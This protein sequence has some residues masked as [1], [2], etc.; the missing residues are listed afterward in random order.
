MNIQDWF[1]VRI[2]WLDLLAVQ[3]TLKCLLQHHGSK[4]SVLQ[5][6][7]FFMVQF[8]HPHMTPGKTKA[9]IFGGFISHMYCCSPAGSTHCMD[10]SRS[11]YGFSI[12]FTPGPSVC[13][14][15][16]W[17]VSTSPQG[18][19]LHQG[20]VLL[21][22]HGFQ[23][24]ICSPHFVSIFLF[25]CLLSSSNIRQED[26]SE[27]HLRPQLYKVKYYLEVIS[28]WNPDWCRGKWCFYMLQSTTYNSMRLLY[29]HY[30]QVPCNFCVWDTL[31]KY[32]YSSPKSVWDTLTRDTLTLLLESNKL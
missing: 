6:S 17:K 21:C 4:A 9:L 27:F 22:P 2:D 7:A 1:P 30:I 8:S 19:V 20:W 3:G 13:L 18:Y 10:V 15:L 31:T 11:S 26:T 5:H 29:L 14:V 32:P 24:L 12:T 28:L 23:L 25:Y 16:Y